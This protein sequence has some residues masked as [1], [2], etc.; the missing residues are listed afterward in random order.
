M[1]SSPWAFADRLPEVVEVKH[2]P[3]GSSARF[4]CRV[5]ARSTGQAALLY[6]LQGSWRVTGLQL[7]PGVAT[8]AYY[9]TSRW[10]NVYHWVRAEGGTLGYYV[11]IA[12]PARLERDRVEWTDLGVD[13]LVVPG[14]PPQVLDEEEMWNLPSRLREPARRSLL[15][16]LRAWR[17]LAASTE[18]RT[19]RLLVGLTAGA[20]APPGSPGSGGGG[21]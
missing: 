14:H 11:N 9:W 12:T 16:V 7:D 15:A 17:R 1:T 13:V 21:R 4:S 2:R 10:Y 8:F 18:A 3:D 5:L 19:R 20:P 6:V